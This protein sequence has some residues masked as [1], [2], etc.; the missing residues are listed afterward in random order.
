MAG[1]LKLGEGPT[2]GGCS[3]SDCP[4]D[5]YKG[6]RIDTTSPK[7]SGT[8]T[9]F[10]ASSQLI[11]V[12]WDEDKTCDTGFSATAPTCVSVLTSGE[13]QVTGTMSGGALTLATSSIVAGAFNGWTIIVD[14]DGNGATATDIHTGIITSYSTAKVVTI[15]WINVAGA[16]HTTVLGNGSFDGNVRACCSRE[17][18]ALPF[19]VC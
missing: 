3:A 2:G 12:D 13:T 8:I 10:T 18:E 19:L 4:D 6:W 1:A 16:P 17:S 14:I 15:D 7:A 11:T 5:Y 9:G